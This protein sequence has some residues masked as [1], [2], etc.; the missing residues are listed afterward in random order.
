MGKK[1]VLIILAVAGVGAIVGGIFMMKKSS[2]EKV[3]SSTGDQN[4]PVVPETTEPVVP[5]TGEGVM[6]GTSEKTVEIAVEGSN[7]K[8]AP[9]E[10]RV[11][12][13]ENIRLVFKS[14]GGIHDFVIDEFD[15]TTSQIGDGEEEEVEFVADKVGTFAYFCSV[16]NHRKIGMEGKLVVE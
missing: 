15:V 1:V 14:A 12:K 7:Y 16:G 11:K 2:P 13:G 9:A 5:A 8:F 10:I 4:M 3:V 6:E